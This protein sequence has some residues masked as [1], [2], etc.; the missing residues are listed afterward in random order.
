MDKEEIESNLR[1][2]MDLVPE[3]EGLIAAKK[4]NG[5]VIV[6]RTITEMDHDKIAQAAVKILDDS[7][8]LKQSIGKGKVKN[9]M[10]TLDDGFAVLVE[11]KD[12]IFI[13]LA[14]KDGR[15]SLGLLKRNLESISEK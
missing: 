2:L 12:E 11:G 3:C 15:A 14:G 13:A 6:G 1:D 7:T 9:T 5:E 10:V 4:D 8:N